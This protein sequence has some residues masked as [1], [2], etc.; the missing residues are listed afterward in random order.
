MWW[1]CSESTDFAAAAD[2]DAAAHSTAEAAP[3]AAPPL[4]R[5]PPA[6][7]ATRA[8]RSGLRCGASLLLL[9][10]WLRADSPQR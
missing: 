2:A 8:P 4:A 10:T 5:V 7:A 1:C 3:T 6:E 9:A